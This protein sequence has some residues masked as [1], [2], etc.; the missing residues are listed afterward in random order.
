VRDHA[1]KYRGLWEWLT[2]E[3]RPEVNA[4]F[5]QLEDV[6]GFSLPR[7]CRDHQPHWYGYEGSAVARAIID[8]GWRA[9]HVNLA[10]ET[11]TL[12]RA[13]GNART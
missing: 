7:S 2:R 8:A 1:G 5:S 3:S 6:L 4:T 11:V 10:E 9:H 12:T 13:T